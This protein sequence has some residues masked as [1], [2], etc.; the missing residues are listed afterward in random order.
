[1]LEVTSAGV[2]RFLDLLLRHCRQ[3]EGIAVDCSEA[4]LTRARDRF[5][6]H[7]RV[8]IVEHDLAD[9]LPD[10]GRFDVIVSSFAIHHLTDARKRALYGE[11]FALLA[12]GG[13]FCN[14]EHVVSPTPR[15]HAA[16]YQ[17]MGITPE[18]EDPSSKL[19]DVETQLAWLREIGIIDVDCL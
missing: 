10:L 8:R 12:P 5:A 16:F 3:A 4:M 19:V 11:L 7:P 14:L 17:A 6:G 1:M 13:L 9:P 15:L 18:D 2:R